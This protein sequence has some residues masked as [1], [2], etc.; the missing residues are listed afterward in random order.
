MNF[1]DL[2]AVRDAAFWWLGVWAAVTMCNC[3]ACN[4]MARRRERRR[5]NHAKYRAAFF[6]EIARRHA[7]ED[8]EAPE[9]TE[10][11]HETPDA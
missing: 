7:E 5:K 3:T 8:A 6:V 10:V 2:L 4:I 11:L 1:S 9:T